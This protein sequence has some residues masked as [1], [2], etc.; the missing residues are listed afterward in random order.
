MATD[1]AAA[2]VRPLRQAV[3]RP[4]RPPEESVYPGDDDR[5]AAHLAVRDA[6]GA[7]VAVGSLLLED[8]LWATGRFPGGCWRVR[9]MAT[10]RGARRRGYGR[11]VLDGLLLRAGARGDALVWCNARTPALSFYLRA[12]FEP[13][14]EPFTLPTIGE[15]QSMQR[16][17]P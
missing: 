15:H 6:A 12:G 9:G 16:R 4:G 5:R 10:R 1:V 2:L 14:G 17:V 3:L 13:V 7:V 11:V 8:P